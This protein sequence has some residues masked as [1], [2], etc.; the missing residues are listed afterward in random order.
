MKAT[1][2]G[3]HASR[4]HRSSSTPFAPYFLFCARP[5]CWKRKREREKERKRERERDDKPFR[6]AFSHPSQ[7]Q[8]CHRQEYLIGQFPYGETI[9]Q[10]EEKQ[11][12]GEDERG[13][14]LDT[15]ARKIS[16][17]SLANFKRTYLLDPK[18]VR[19][20]AVKIFFASKKRTMV[21]IGER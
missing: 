10:P 16:D 15:S 11:R 19:R 5:V 20:T 21:Q 17:F 18:R 2:V 6:Q 9:Q 3:R 13:R 12:E 14:G 1:K 4:L 7:G 8:G